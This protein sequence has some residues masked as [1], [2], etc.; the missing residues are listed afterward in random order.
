MRSI[1]PD[2]NGQVW[3][4]KEFDSQTMRLFSR[5]SRGS[6]AWSERHKC[7]NLGT[8]WYRIHTKTA[9]AVNYQGKE[10]DVCFVA[11]VGLKSPAAHSAALR[12][13]RQLTCHVD[14]E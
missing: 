5:P 6:T 1:E 7:P 10:R 9:I 3:A 2:A 12:V 4:S 14:S 13:E 11:T 8:P